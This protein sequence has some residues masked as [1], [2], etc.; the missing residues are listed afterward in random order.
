MDSVLPLPPALFFP[1]EAAVVEAD[2][3]VTRPLAALF[4]TVLLP[5]L[6]PAVPVP[7]PAAGA[8]FVVVVTT[9]VVVVLTVL[10]V[11]TAPSRPFFVEEEATCLGA[12]LTTFDADLELVSL[13]I[14]LSLL[15]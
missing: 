15:C 4:K 10:V 12:A 5:P 7:E 9:V 13:P 11:V 2:D 14:F 6:L 8:F 1:A 3:F